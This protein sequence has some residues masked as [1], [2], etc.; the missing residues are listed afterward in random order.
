MR[1]NYFNANDDLGELKSYWWQPDRP[2]EA[3]EEL[4]DRMNVWCEK[5]KPIVAIHRDCSGRLWWA[6]SQIPIGSLQ[7]GVSIRATV[8]AAGGRMIGTH[9]P[10]NPWH[11]G[12]QTMLRYELGQVIAAAEKPDI[13]IC[14]SVGASLKFGPPDRV[15][16]DWGPPGRPACDEA[17]KIADTMHMAGLLWTMAEEMK[18]R[19][20]NGQ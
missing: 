11:P 1:E 12:E 5:G 19:R 13:V 10:L 8:D 9:Q 6:Y 4:A 18:L 16:S 3:Q 14:A 17:V 20:E 2:T 7:L 15:Y